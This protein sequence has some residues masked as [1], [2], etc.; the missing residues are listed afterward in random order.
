VHRREPRLGGAGGR[1]HGHGAL[2]RRG[3]VRCGGGCSGP[4]PNGSGGDKGKKAATWANYMARRRW[5]V[6]GGRWGGAF[7]ELPSEGKEGVCVVVGGR[8]DGGLYG[9]RAAA[10]TTK[11]R[12]RRRKRNR[13]RRSAVRVG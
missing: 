9:R 11:K 8:D 13:S 4:V 12:R 3:A 5:A 1:W 2:P 6:G 7:V 10:R